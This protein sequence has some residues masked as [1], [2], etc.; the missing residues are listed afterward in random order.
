MKNLGITLIGLI[1]A[2]PLSAQ[3]CM[4]EYASV[5]GIHIPTIENN[6]AVDQLSTVL[7]LYSPHNEAVDVTV[8][9]KDFFT[10][11]VIQE[12]TITF[13]YRGHGSRL[14]FPPREGIYQLV[15]RSTHEIAV[16]GFVY[17]MCEDNQRMAALVF[18]EFSCTEP[19][20][21]IVEIE[22]YECPN[23]CPEIPPC[24]PCGIPKDK[25]PLCHA[26]T[27]DN[28]GAGTHNWIQMYLPPSA[29]EAHLREHEMDYIGLCK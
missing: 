18:K 10:G 21:P 16:G 13:H 29:A 5:I 25:L 22:T 8:L 3:P 7:S 19:V 14:F 12:K 11:R 28:Q 4:W 17:G 2:A 15:V 1:L 20:E 26:A 23:P 9:W 27:P 24:P 6:P